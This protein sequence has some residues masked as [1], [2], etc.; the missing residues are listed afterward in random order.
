LV[1]STL[2]VEEIAVS[3]IPADGIVDV[4]ER[5]R[6]AIGDS[7]EAFQLAAN[8]LRNRVSDLQRELERYQNAIDIMDECRMA[9]YDARS[10]VITD[11][12]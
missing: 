9:L 7:H 10:S 4:A 8:I 2:N 5:M 1:L 3:L 11:K 6:Y 12:V